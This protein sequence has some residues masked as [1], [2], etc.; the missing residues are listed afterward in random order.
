MRAITF[1]FITS[2]LVII[3]GSTVLAANGGYYIGR[4]LTASGGG[5]SSSQ[6]YLTQDIIGQSA[7]G[8]SR[9]EDYLL[10]SG[11]YGPYPPVSIT[12]P[13]EPKED[14]AVG[15][16]VFPVNKMS[17]LMPWI[18]LVVVIVAGGIILARRRAHS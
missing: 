5:I 15:G 12:E 17:L 18:A 4:G 13:E 10:Y 11:F 14:V 9:S 6:G 7:A 16:E 3:A 8:V 1:V 2:V